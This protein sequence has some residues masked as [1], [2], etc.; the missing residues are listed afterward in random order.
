MEKPHDP[1]LRSE[2]GAILMRNGLKQDGLRWLFS[3]LQTDPE[4]AATHALLAD[5]FEKEAKDPQRA[6]AHRRMA[7]QAQ[8]EKGQ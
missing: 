8:G 7:G 3:A 5:Y 4:H 2:A 6:Q 1:A